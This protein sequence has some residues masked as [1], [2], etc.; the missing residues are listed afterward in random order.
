MGGVGRSG[1][2]ECAADGVFHE[3]QHAGRGVVAGVPG[4]EVESA[5]RL[6][7]RVAH[8]EAAERF[9]GDLKLEFAGDDR[10]NDEAGVAVVRR[11]GAG[12]QVKLKDDDLGTGEALLVQ[13]GIVAQV[14]EPW[15]V[16]AAVVTAAAALAL[17]LV[18]ALVQVE[19]RVRAA[20]GVMIASHWRP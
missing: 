4:D 18:L 11:R 17:V 13:E 12:G 19:A 16:Q 1:Q 5:G 8:A 7:E 20:L 9:A 10:A 3:Y 15:V 14:G 2:D 6:V